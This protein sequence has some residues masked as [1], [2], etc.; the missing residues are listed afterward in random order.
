MNA[1]LPL[2]SVVVPAHNAGAYLAECLGSA[3]AQEGPFE[4]EVI[5][6]DDGST[7]DTA[8]VARALP[9]V[10][11]LHQAQRGPSAARNAGIAAARG[12]YVALLDADDVWPPGKL[13]CQLPILMAAPEAGLVFGDCRQFD[14]EGPRA[15][16]QFEANRLGVVAWGPGPIVPDAYVRLLEDNFVTTGSVVLRRD[17]LACTGGFAED[18]RLVEDLDLWLRVARSHA[19]AWTDQVCLLRRRHESN[20]SRDAEAMS[21]AYL[22]VLRRQLTRIGAAEQDLV[23]RIRRLAATE[24][25]QLAKAALRQ[26]RIGLAAHRAWR[27]LSPLS[28]NTAHAGA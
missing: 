23:A 24:H 12:D 13:A 18:L 22:D 14:A 16:T 3:L 17:V 2:V 20:T 9:R 8:A 1:G 27:S 21:L 19:I 4:T 25:R 15:T 5:V 6:V 10:R 26:G 7:D 28:G 11:Y